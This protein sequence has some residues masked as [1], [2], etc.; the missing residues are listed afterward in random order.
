[1]PAILGIDAAWTT[2]QPS[3]V[4]LIQ[5]QPDGWHVRCAAPSY[6]SF[7]N[8][9]GGVPVNWSS[10]QTRG[11]APDISDLLVAARNLGV[12]KVD[13]IALDIPLAH[14]KIESRRPSDSA[15]SKAF[16]G[17]GCSTHSPT[18]ERPGPISDDLMAQLRK[19]GYSLETTSPATRSKRRVLEV[20]P[21]PALLAL[22][23]RDYRV[24]Y[25]VS[26]SSKYWKGESVPTRIER[27]LNEFSGIFGA[28]QN[29]FGDLGFELPSKLD[30]TTLSALKRYEDGL[31]AL[32]CAWVGQQHLQGNTRPYG[33]I[34]SAIWVPDT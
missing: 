22:L 34:D 27:L 28:L 16:G 9:A 2:A 25:K 32:V 12:D 13:L 23:K 21:H 6:E 10:S 29:V 11:S 4:A 26:N 3:G 19:I 24:P 8:A 5:E 14:T 31:D 18:S 15:I 1:M 30:I 33:D 7:V 20:Y 17:K